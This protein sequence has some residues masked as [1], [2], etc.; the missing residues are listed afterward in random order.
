MSLPIPV[1]AE[2]GYRRVVTAQFGGDNDVNIRARTTE[3]GYA[4]T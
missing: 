4:D 1:L 2:V 3:A